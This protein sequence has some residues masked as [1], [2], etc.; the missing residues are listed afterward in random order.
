MIYQL[1]KFI[2]IGTINTFVYYAIYALLIFA[3]FDYRISVL[4]ATILGVFFSFR[5]L[6]KFVFL[7]NNINLI[8]KFVLVYILIFILNISLIQAFEGILLN[9]YVSGLFAAICCAIPSFVF[10]KYFVFN[11]A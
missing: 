11:G 5:T 4:F 1:K 9:Y 2:V 8:Y 10:N 7:D 3:E 6:G